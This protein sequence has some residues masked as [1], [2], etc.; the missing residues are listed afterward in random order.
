MPVPQCTD[1]PASP[2]VSVL[3]SGLLLFR[4][5]TSGAFCDV[6][7]L[8][9]DPEHLFS[10]VVRAREGGGAPYTLWRHFG[11]LGN[12]LDFAVD[13]PS[14]R[15]VCRYLPTSGDFDRRNPNNDNDWRWL[16]HLNEFHSPEPQFKSFDTKP[17]IRFFSGSFNTV[18]RT[19]PD[20]TRVTYACGGRE[21]DLYSVA[22]VA[23]ANVYLG[24][25]RT[26]TLTTPDGDEIRMPKTNGRTYEISIENDPAIVLPPSAE[27]RR[28]HF[29]VY[30][31]AMFNPP[32]GMCEIY[33]QAM[34]DRK[35]DSTPDVPCMGLGVGG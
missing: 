8:N 15:G 1:L 27:K 19:K 9:I 30:Y 11:P 20:R 31:G 21:N 33:Y 7:V 17:G 26:A 25:G 32:S 28:S 5:D 35:L 34:S 12:A 22:S 2:D 24:P 3:F 6:D 29:H 23:G 14:P 4:F 18:M 13:D 10:I 16:L